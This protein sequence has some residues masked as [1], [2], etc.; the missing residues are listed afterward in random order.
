MKTIAILGSQASFHEIAAQHYYKEPINIISCKTP[1]SVL[2]EIR[3]NPNC[4]S[5]ILAIENTIA[6]LI[7]NHYNSLQQS[8]IKIHG[9]ILLNVQHHL[10]ALPGTYVHDIWE[11]KTHPMA[12]KQCT[13][14][15]SRVHP[16]TRLVE[17]SDTASAAKEIAT[18]KLEGVAAIASELACNYYG[19]EIIAP[20]IQNN[21]TNYTRFF[22][23]SK[24]RQE[25]KQQHNKATM[26]FRLSH[27]IG[28]LT[29]VL[30]QLQEFEINLSK[31]HSFPLTTTSEEYEFIIDLEFSDLNLF[32]ELLIQLRQT[33]KGLQVLGTYKKDHLS[34]SLALTKN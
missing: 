14:Y 6:G 5:G 25:Q 32:Q 10:V 23:L 15:L 19:L 4:S 12:I 24:S 18:K 33:T 3:N 16:S 13:N 8:N 1:E 7:P 17:C 22:V 2:E 28:S 31:L 20:N 34:S 29:K 9:E 11:V 27:Q 21:K 30:L 26:T